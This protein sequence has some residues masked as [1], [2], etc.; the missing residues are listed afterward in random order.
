LVNISVNPK[1]SQAI[2]CSLLILSKG[3]KYRYNF[4]VAARKLAEITIIQRL[5]N[6]LFARFMVCKLVANELVYPAQNY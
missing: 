3:S 6:G 5:Y 4:G 1:P 2:A